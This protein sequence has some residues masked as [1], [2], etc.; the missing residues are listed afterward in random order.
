MKRLLLSL[1]LGSLL[2]MGAG[3]GENKTLS[4]ITHKPDPTNG[5]LIKSASLTTVYYLGPD[6]KRYVF[7]TD[8][9]YLSWFETFSYVKTV[10]DET[11]VTAPLG[12]NVTY[13]PTSRLLK[14][15]T[16][17]KVYAVAHGGVLRWISN[18][19][20]A[21]ELYGKNWKKEVHDLPDAF[22]TNYTVGNPIINASDFSR[23]SEEEAST[24]IDQDKGLKP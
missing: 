13:R 24:S 20:I 18:E 11:L 4:S 22:F 6:G 9:T 19:T 3:C 15:E 5:H 14:I 1:S 2:L 17:P 10:P 7:P 8:K 21:I 16:D 23:A 12:G